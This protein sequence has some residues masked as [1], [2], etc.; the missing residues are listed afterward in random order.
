MKLKNMFTLYKK[1][2]S[3][4]VSTWMA[5]RFNFYLFLIGLIL[6][7]LIGPALVYLIYY[8][9]LS[10][11]G[12]TLYEVLLLSGMFIIV[13]ALDVFLFAPIQW[14]VQGMVRGG[15][16]DKMMIRPIKPLHFLFLRKPEV[17]SLM[18][19]ALGLIIVLFSISKLELVF[20]LSQIPKFIVIFMAALAFVA[21]LRIIVAS[22]VFYFTRAEAVAQFI[23]SMKDF[24]TYPISIYGVFGMF[25][26][27]FIFPIG[28][29]SFYPAQVILGV[30]GWD[31]I[32]KVSM[33]AVSF[34]LV[35]LLFWEQAIKHYTSAGG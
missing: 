27:S 22:L 13:E 31:V 23:S 6:F 1:G 16:F 32:L 19:M 28:V 21:G 14:Q 25:L 18:E 35:S 20:S 26:F 17:A 7:N 29:L 8:N 24:V 11:P 3:L 33:V 4:Q 2:F 34:L 10:F 12:W 9:S 30:V 15:H 5:Y